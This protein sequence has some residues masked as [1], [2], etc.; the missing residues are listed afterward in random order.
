MFDPDAHIPKPNKTL[1][2]YGACI[3]AGMRLARAT[4]VNTRVLPTIAA[5]NESVEL[6]HEIFNRIF[7]RVP[8]QMGDNHGTD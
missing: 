4:Q 6:S 3:I 5:I 8:A 1:I 2:Y 7:R